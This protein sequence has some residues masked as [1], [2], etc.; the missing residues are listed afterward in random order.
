M[1]LVAALSPAMCRRLRSFATWLDSSLHRPSGTHLHACAR[2][3]T[4]ARSR[5]WACTR[6]RKRRWQIPYACAVVL[7]TFLGEVGLPSLSAQGVDAV[8]AF[9]G[10]FTML[11]GTQ[12][13]TRARARAHL[14]KQRTVRRHTPHHNA[15]SRLGA[16]CTS[17]HGISGTALLLVHAWVAVPMMFGGGIV[18]A[19]IANAASDS[20]LLFGT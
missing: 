2:A 9:L 18:T 14:T 1:T 12:T 15:G 20:W 10:G 8:S 5:A 3:C 4:R 19:V 16:G 7:G 11:F 13:H 17:G 6:A